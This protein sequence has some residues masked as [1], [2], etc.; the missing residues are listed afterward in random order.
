MREPE[1]LRV[2]NFPLA[3]RTPREAATL[4]K[5]RR[6][7]AVELRDIA[8]AACERNWSLLDFI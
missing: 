1:A 2:A 3:A 4:D 7:R 5:M 6:L 8:R